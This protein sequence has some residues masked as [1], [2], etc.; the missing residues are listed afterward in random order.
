M[1]CRGCEGLMGSLGSF[2]TRREVAEVDTFDW[3]G[4][5]I[6]TNPH[7]SD[8]DLA[9]F[10]EVAGAIDLE[11]QKQAVAALGVVKQFLRSSV[12]PEDFEAFWQTG[13]DNGQGIA[14]LLQVSMAIVTGASGRPTERP[15]GSSDG[16][17][18]TLAS[19]PHDAAS[20]AAR[21]YPDRPDLQVATLRAVS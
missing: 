13:K 14:D 8:L 4:R 7:L 12:D 10:M 5:E 6:R 15:S 3:F 21:A 20:V 9:D 2:G 16:P 11:D 18:I 17:S 1:V 19:S